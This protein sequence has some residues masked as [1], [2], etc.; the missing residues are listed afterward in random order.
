[1]YW[2]FDLKP[3]DVFCFLDIKLDLVT[4][5]GYGQWLQ[6]PSG[7]FEEGIPTYPDTGRFAG[8]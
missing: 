5:Y 6:R 7:Y 2:T 8:R 4:T 1:M 3:T